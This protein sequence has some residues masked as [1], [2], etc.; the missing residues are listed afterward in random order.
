[1]QFSEI[2]LR[3]ICGFFTVEYEVHRTTDPHF[4][5]R[6]LIDAL[7]DSAAAKL[8]EVFQDQLPGL[9]D[10]AILFAVKNLLLPL[11][12][13]APQFGFDPLALSDLL[14]SITHKF[15]T[16]MIGERIA[17]I[18]AVLGQE[19]WQRF[20]VTGA[21]SLQNNVI[22][23][24]IPTESS[25]SSSVV[26]PPD[27]FP[28]VMPFS[29]SIPVICKHIR[30]F[31]IDIFAFAND[32][33][34]PSE[35]VPQ[36]AQFAVFTPALDDSLL[37]RWFCELIARVAAAFRIFL[38]ENQH[39][40]TLTSST[41][42][43]E[44]IST[45]SSPSTTSSQGS[46]IG[47][48]TTPSTHPV[49]ILQMALLASNATTFVSICDGLAEEFRSRRDQ[50]MHRI[51][52]SK[53]S[54]LDNV[55]TLGQTSD[56]WIPPSRG[57]TAEA[58]S[59]ASLTE[60]DVGPM[61]RRVTLQFSDLSIAALDACAKPLLAEIDKR[62]EKAAIT[63]DSPSTADPPAPHPFFA[64]LLTF[65]GANL[66]ALDFLSLSLSRRLLDQL[67]RH[68]IRVILLGLPL[69]E[70]VKKL[71]QTTV[72]TL[73]SDLDA[74][75]LFAKRR[76]NSPA[77]SP[78]FHEVSATRQLF[79]LVLSED[80]DPLVSKATRQEKFPLAVP[81]EAAILFEKLRESTSVRT[82]SAQQ[83]RAVA[84][85]IKALKSQK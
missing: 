63:W 69:S 60:D 47:S 39:L 46:K 52:P 45:L 71:S 72:V 65:L 26:Q 22:A 75:E 30:G 61:M 43:L 7:W 58:P 76:M 42:T 83:R 23:L 24:H 44:S 50:L 68:I 2:W 51:D 82:S 20:S 53:R 12:Q 59:L 3:Q 31:L 40:L 55:S 67:V 57:Q 21:D 66:S 16:A 17:R 25:T 41:P 10:P 32:D 27:R 11:R 80:L 6:P 8:R 28:R 5:P 81:S 15:G 85:I 9:K 29:N 73:R 62:A 56:S 1:M 36:Q 64:E 78:L 38:N 37:L 33:L 77:I 70:K 18:E 35:Y 54:P 48:P 13:T 79:D 74:L 34:S 14:Q 19:S 4:L 84:A 49:D